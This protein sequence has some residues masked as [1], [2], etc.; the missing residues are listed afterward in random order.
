MTPTRQDLLAALSQIQNH[1]ACVNQDILTITGCGMTD[2]EVRAHLIAVKGIGRWT[3]DMFLMFYLHRSDVLPTGDLG[4]QKGVMKL[5]KLRSMP[6]PEKME[7]VTESWRP[8]RTVAA[9]YL[10]NIADEDK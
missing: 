9:R 5:F 8:Y 10:W 2:D 1:P 6:T 3:A 7:K 4:I